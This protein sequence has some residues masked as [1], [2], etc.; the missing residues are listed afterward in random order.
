MTLENGMT[1]HVH[2]LIELNIMK[3]T[4]T[5]SYLGFNATPIKIPILFV[6]WIEGKTI[7]KFVGNHKIPWI[8]QAILNK[9][10]SAGEFT[11]I[12][13]KIYQSLVAIKIAV[14]VT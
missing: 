12:D 8:A 11:I 10:N 4:I 14:T 2:W 7:L 6:T 9:T 13:L 5:K 3:M 1:S